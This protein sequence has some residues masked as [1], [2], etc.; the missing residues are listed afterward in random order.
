MPV[1]HVEHPDPGRRATRPISNAI[2]VPSGD[3]DGK[4]TSGWS[5]STWP[6]EP[7]ASITQ[8]LPTTTR[9]DL[10]ADER[11][12]LAVR[13]P[14]RRVVVQG[15]A[16]E[17]GEAD[18]VRAVRVHHVDVRGA[19]PVAL[20]GD[21][22]AV[23]REHREDVDRRAARQ[24]SDVRAVGR[25]RVD[26]GGGRA[27]AVRDG[28]A[29]EERDALAIGRPGVRVVATL[30]VPEPRDLGA[31]RSARRTCRCPSTDPRRSR[32]RWMPVSGPRRPLLRL[33]AGVTRSC[34]ARSRRHPR[35]RRRA[36]W[37]ARRRRSAG[38]APAA[39]AERR[40][41]RREARAPGTARVRVRGGR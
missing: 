18:D 15:V 38:C 6:S 23:G 19:G 13:R 16:L 9:R 31:V 40:R 35:S 26:V 22:R 37:P 34:R 7:S 11:D 30:V 12:P 39:R 36:R 3:H 21:P 29:V 20:E 28:D 25:H 5:R 27:L 33:S 10:A 17:P 2:L 8:S 1:L 14:R 32:G 24:L 4:S 41:A